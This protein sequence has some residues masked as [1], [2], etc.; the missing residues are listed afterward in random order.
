MQYVAAWAVN[1]NHRSD[2]SRGCL[3]AVEIE[4][5]LQHASDCGDNQRKMLRQTASHHGIGGDL[6]DGGDSVQRR[7]DPKLKPYPARAGNH[8]VNRYRCGR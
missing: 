3:H 2:I 1:D 6:L 5:C 8:F 7:N 4:P